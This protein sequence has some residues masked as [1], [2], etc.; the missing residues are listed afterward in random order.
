MPKD[1]SAAWSNLEAE[2]ALLGSVLLDNE[3]LKLAREAIDQGDLFSEAHRYLFTLMCEFADAGRPIDLVTI[4]EKIASNG[5]LEKVGGAGHLA[6][7]TEGVPIG[8]SVAVSEYARIIKEKA[9][10]RQLYNSLRN[11]EARIEQGE[12]LDDLVESAHAQIQDLRLQEVKIRT[13]AGKLEVIGKVEPEAEKKKPAEI[14]HIYPRIPPEAWHPAAELYRRAHENC[15]EGSDN[16]HFITF[17]TVLG[18]MLGRTLG[19]RM[20]GM[21]YGNLYSVLVGQIGGDGKDT[22]ADFGTDLIQTV[23]KEVYIPEAIVS[24]AGFCRDWQAFNRREQITSNHRA[25]LRLSEIRTYL[26]ATS[27]SGPRAV[28]GMMLTHYGARYSLDNPSVATDAH[29]RYPHLSMLACGAKRFIGQIPENDLINGLGRR[30][31]FVPG[32]AKGPNADPASPDSE[33]LVPLADEIRQILE[34]YR[35]ISLK[36]PVVLRLEE[37]AKKL[38]RE[39]YTAYWKRKRGDD[40]LSALNNGDRVTCR[41]IAL[42]NAGLEKSEGYIRVEHLERA[43]AFVEFLVE[44]RYPIFS[45]HGAGPSLEVEKKIL[46]RVPPYPGRIRKRWL[47]MNCRWC[48]SKTFNDRLKSLTAEDGPLMTHREGQKVWISR[49]S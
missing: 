33:I 20:G 16:W 1:P 46:S 28:S 10:A 9:R 11:L 18:S 24:Q 25:L 35:T 43:I 22:C 2:R 42:M 30:L 19:T 32:D 17:Y 13:E 37:P 12:S 3:A 47:Q 23:D 44:C 29:I 7:L 27:D 6:S 26:D 48:D 41:K 21:V 5:N 49:S 34:M 8:A 36:A 15:T 38:W 39:W 14:E 31:C 45:E 40:L 4:S